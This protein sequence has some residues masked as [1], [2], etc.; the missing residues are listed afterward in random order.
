M[1]VVCCSCSTQEGELNPAY[2][3]GERGE[4]VGTQA[5]LELNPV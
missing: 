5:A 4:L 2:P 1:T 3:A